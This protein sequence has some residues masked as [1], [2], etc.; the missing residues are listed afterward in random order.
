MRERNSI[1]T[2]DSWS[3]AE[4]MPR[5]MYFNTNMF[6][7]LPAALDNTGKA[8]TLLK[9]Y[10]GDD[11]A[12]AAEQ[13]ERIDVRVLLSDPAAQELPEEQTIGRGLIKRF[14]PD[15]YFTVPPKKGIEKRLEVRLNNAL[16]AEPGVE[17]GW[18]V[19]RAI[20]PKL[21][22]VGNNLIGI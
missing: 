16:L 9:V 13:V 12:A 21:F 11:V 6:A 18:L 20:D 22:A 2:G 7:P 8:D 10:V 19:F 1:N 17:D 15:R 14:G 5:L 3:I 4:L